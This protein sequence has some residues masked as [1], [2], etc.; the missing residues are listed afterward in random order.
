MEKTEDRRKGKGS[1]SD[2]DQDAVEPRQSVA[3]G[4]FPL[5]EDF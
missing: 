3:W 5:H 2:L 1:A 4:L